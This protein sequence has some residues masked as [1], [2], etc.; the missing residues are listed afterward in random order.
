MNWN[1]PPRPAEY[2]EKALISAILNNEF[3][4]G[5]T[6]PGE[7][8]LAAQLGVTRPTL[9]EVLQRLDRDGWLDIQHG[10]ATRVTDYWREGGL[11]VLSALVRYGDTLP[12]EFIPNL[13]SV[14]LALA[15]TYTRLAVEH[16]PD[17]VVQ[18]LAEGVDL[19]DIPQSFAA[20]DWR[21]H[22]AL[23]V[24]S[25][26]PVFTLILNGF[27]GFYEQM[28]V[29]YFVSE[30]ARLASKKFYTYLQQAAQRADADGAERLAREIMQKSIT[31]WM[32]TS[33]MPASTMKTATGD[34]L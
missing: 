1:A 28:A 17:Q 33:M 9:R 13:L 31:I 11:N 15:P 12:P 32:Q 26:N 18:L 29:K 4:P 7:R 16:H 27:S 25:E 22:H 14:R 8:D 19:P 24:A 23:T 20:F 34:T 10:K 30:T 21:L 2:A 5:S 6:L 3:P